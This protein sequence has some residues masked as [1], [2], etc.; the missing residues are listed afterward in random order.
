MMYDSLEEVW[1]AVEAEKADAAVVPHPPTAHYLNTHRENNLQ[2]VGKV[3]SVQPEGIAV[4][5]GNRELL[6]KLNK[7][8]ETIKENGTYDHIYEK[9][10]GAMY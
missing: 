6:E 4:Q 8:L 9:W 10:F 3:F 2:M 1:T 5:K 7:S